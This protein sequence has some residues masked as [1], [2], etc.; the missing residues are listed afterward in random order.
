[1]IDSEILKNSFLF[2]GL[3]P[4]LVGHLAAAARPVGLDKDQ[5]LF[6]EGDDSDGFYAI[7]EGAVRVSV[8]SDE[9]EERIIAILCDGEIVGELGLI[10]GSQR[11][12]RVT[13]ARPSRLAFVPKA[14]FERAA[15]ANPAI[16][17]H[18]LRVVG[19]RL[20]ET[21]VSRRLTL[22]EGGAVVADIPVPPLVDAAPEYDRP[23]EATPPQPVVAPHEV[24]APSDLGDALRRLIGSPDLAS[25]RWIWEQYD[26]MVRHGTVVRP[27]QASSGVVRVFRPDGLSAKGIA[28]S[29]GCNSRFVYLDPA[30]GSRLA[31]ASA[32]ADLVA[33]GAKPL[34]AARF[35]IFSSSH[36]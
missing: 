35:S 23:W 15:D 5:I 13:G 9:G 8:V 22:T 19:D 31:V 26:H 16:Y 17:R 24:P 1:M 12:A 10:D 21:N 30:E 28:I 4:E 6:F 11:S 18:M 29:A 14:G 20:R 33:V 27:G 34:R 7:L 2:E 3:D 36:S 25:R 32:Y